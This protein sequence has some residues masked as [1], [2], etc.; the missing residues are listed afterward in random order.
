MKRAFTFVAG[1]LAA[2]Q[3]AFASGLKPRDFAPE[4]TNVKAVS[5]KE[6]VDVSL[7]DFRDKYVVLLFYPFDFT[8]VCPTELIAFSE[9]L[10]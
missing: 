2:T 7:A 4:F 9:S 3:T 10:G 8:Y 6:F 1:M 5:N